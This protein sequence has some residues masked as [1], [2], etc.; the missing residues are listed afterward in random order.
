MHAT[1]NLKT[2]IVMR[3]VA[4]VALSF[5]EKTEIVL[6]QG[7]LIAVPPL[8]TSNKTRK[9]KLSMIFSEY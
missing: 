6:D 1:C 3:Y 7:Q 5:K 8:H 4:P 9:K 2:M